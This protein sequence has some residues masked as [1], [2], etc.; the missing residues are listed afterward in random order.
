MRQALF[1]GICIAF[2]GLTACEDAPTEKVA[3]QAYFDVPGFVKAQTVRLEKENAAVQ[4]TV[5]LEPEKPETQTQTNVNWQTELA[6]FQEIDLNKKALQGLYTET[7]TLLPTG[8]KLLYT[9]AA[10]NDAPIKQLEILTDK[11]QQVTQLRAIYEQQ[12]ALFFN[13]EERALQTNEQ[14]RLKAFA[15]T[16]V[17][18]VLLF[19]SL[20]YQVKSILP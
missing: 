20:Y 9:S 14:G 4:K 19:D 5:G 2:L 17:Q 16:G 1:T 7:K 3:D 15:I 18:K 6:L 11:D 12:N 10:N 13:R 8:Q